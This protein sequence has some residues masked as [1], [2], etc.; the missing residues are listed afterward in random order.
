MC[1]GRCTDAPLTS[2]KRSV[3]KLFSTSPDRR[4]KFD[5]GRAQCWAPDRRFT[6]PVAAQTAAAR[7]PDRPGYGSDQ[8]GAYSGKKS[9]VNMRMTCP[10]TNCDCMDLI[11]RAARPNLCIGLVDRSPAKNCSFTRSRVWEIKSCSRLGF[12]T[13][14]SLARWLP[15][16][17]TQNA[18]FVD[19]QYTDGGDEVQ[20]LRDKHSTCA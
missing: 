14:S 10:I 11:G 16:L 7:R 12:P 20:A 1:R 19:L 17:Q 5:I 2:S 15:I 4:G 8:V 3:I 13:R 9:A 18:H 6:D